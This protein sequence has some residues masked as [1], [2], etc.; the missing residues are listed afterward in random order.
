LDVTF[1]TSATTALGSHP[2]R[3]RLSTLIEHTLALDPRPAYREADADRVFAMRIEDVD[4]RFR[5]DRGRVEV[6]AV[7]IVGCGSSP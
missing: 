4:V 6:V 7:D 3:E 2:D 5:I 1:S